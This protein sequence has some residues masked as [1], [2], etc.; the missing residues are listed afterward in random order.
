MP[1]YSS[2]YRKRFLG[3][4]KRLLNQYLKAFRDMADKVA[5]L[6][7][8]PEARF[9]KAFTYTQAPALSAE[10]GR[11][12][13]DF[14]GKLI[15]LT[16]IGIGQSW[17]LSEQ[18]NN[19]IFSEYLEGYRGKKIAELKALPDIMKLEMY[20]ATTKGRFS[21][22]IWRT[23]DQTRKE[24]EVQL[25]FGVM[26]GDS[27]Q[28]I[29]QRIRQYLKNPDALFRRVRD[30]KGNLVAS[31]A[32]AAYHPGRGVYRSAYK[33]AMRV[34]RTE[35]NMS[36]Q[37]ADSERWRNNPVVI[38]IKVSLSGA[39][40]DYNF[41]EICEV[42]EG[43]YPKEFIFEGWHPQC[44]CNA[45]P[46]LMDK[47]MLRRYLRG[48]TDFLGEVQITKYPDRFNQYVKDNYGKL[49]KSSPYWFED[50][51][52]IIDKIVPEPPAVPA[53]TPAPQLRDLLQGEWWKNEDLIKC[54]TDVSPDYK[55]G[56]STG[57]S[58]N[59]DIL[60][61][62]YKLQGF[63]KLPTLIEGSKFPPGEGTFGFRGLYGAQ[64]QEYINDF[65]Y[66]KQFAGRGVFGSGTYIAAP[67]TVNISPA[68]DTALNGYGGGETRNV[69]RIRITPA[70]EARAFNE[71]S[72]EAS[73]FLWDFSD[74]FLKL[75]DTG[76]YSE[77]E[78]K[79]LYDG[80]NK[81]LGDPGRYAALKGIDALYENV[82]PDV[83]Y[84]IV[85]NRGKLEVLK[86]QIGM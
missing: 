68:W 34:A 13:N 29:S 86:E 16:E 19:A 51:K 74:E 78:W 62:I 81:M 27:A 42:L 14:G 21:D 35:T 57:N 9:L 64:A 85:H 79:R 67:R 76:I 24:M 25:A 18:K 4:Q 1:D 56:F 36:Y 83:T 3:N 58:G 39:H 45:T 11:L 5:K 71:I 38:G 61:N 59:D 41:E 2:I 65:K 84:F 52:A 12:M 15:D 46:I 63:D 49:Q 26:R 37:R 72:D 69:M 48:E 7:K 75:K 10:L 54:F 33:N 40:P 32:M 66:G 31:K 22:A 53:A 77:A 82:T 44:L 8:N 43:D 47:A 60:S 30:A 73:K 80:F 23:V 6:S 20:L 28:V 70:M 50:N 55:T 17:R